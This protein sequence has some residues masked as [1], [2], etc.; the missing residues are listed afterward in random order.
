VCNCTTCMCMHA[1]FT[2]RSLTLHTIVFQDA[3]AVTIA[4]F[5]MRR[6]ILTLFAS[7]DASLSIVEWPVRPTNNP[8]ALSACY[9]RRQIMPLPEHI[10]PQSSII[11]PRHTTLNTTQHHGFISAY[12]IR[13]S[14]V[15]RFLPYESPAPSGPPLS[16]FSVLI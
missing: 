16:I 14:L 12:L 9:P 7:P 1:R 3:A 4:F 11:C 10:S 6:T 15:N 5:T 2:T 8:I 13:H